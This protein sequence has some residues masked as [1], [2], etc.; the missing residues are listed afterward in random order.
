MPIGNKNYNMIEIMS[1]LMTQ[2]EDKIPVE[3]KQIVRPFFAHVSEMLANDKA[4]PKLSLKAHEL[5]VFLALW[6]E[7][8]PSS[9]VTVHERGATL[10]RLFQATTDWQKLIN[11]NQHWHFIQEPL[12]TQ[13]INGDVSTNTSRAVHAFLQMVNEAP[14][15]H[16]NH[17]IVTP[18]FANHE[19]PSIADYKKLTCTITKGE[20]I[21]LSNLVEKLSMA[22][23]RRHRQ[24]LESGSFLVKGDHITV[25]H[26]STPT[27]YQ[28]SFF[29]STIERIIEAQDRRS[30]DMSSVFLPPVRFPITTQTWSSLPSTFSEITANTSTPTTGRKTIIFNSLQPTIVFPFKEI[31]D[32][33]TTTSAS[34]IIVFYDNLDRVKATVAKSP[35]KNITYYSH[36]LAHHPFALIAEDT[37]FISEASLTPA[38]K[39]SSSPIS[40]ERAL[41]LIGGLSIGKP[42]VHADHGIGIYEGMQT[43]TIENI[44]KEYLVL[45][46]AQGDALS[47][48]VEFAHKITP[49]IGEGS[50]IVHRLGGTLW[51]K[52][53]KRAKQDAIAFAKELLT[54]A[55]ARADKKRTPYYFDGELEQKLTTSFPFT[56][57]LDQEQ[58]WHEVQ[59]DMGKDQPMDRLIVGDVGFGKTEIAMRAA[60]HAVAMGKQVA[61][62]A[63]TTLLVQ[64]HLDTFQNRL[65]HLKQNIAA[66]SRFSSPTATRLAR[67]G[68]EQDTISIAIGTHALLAKKTI[69]KNLGLVVID[70]EQRFGVGQKE[71]LKKIRASVDV[72][73]LSATPIPRTLSMAL[74]GLRQLSIIATP[75]AG[76]QDIIQQ[77]APQNDSLIIQA[78]TRE[79][80]RGGQVY[81]VAPKVRQLGMIKEHIQA[82]VPHARIAIAHGQMDDTALSKVIHDFDTHGIDI[83]VASS[84]VENGLDLPTANTMLIF[85]APHFGL[86]DLYQLRGRIGRRSAQGYA[87][88]FYTQSELTDVQRARL[89]AL[90]EAS[91]L[92]S[93]WLIAQRDLEI[94]GAGNLLGAD[95]SGTA[96]AIGVQLYM[97]M[98][99]DTLENEEPTAV[100]D[101]SLP[102][103]ALL[104]THY[105]ADMKE[106]TRW[107]LRLTRAK[108]SANLDQH[109]TELT[110]QYGLLPAETKNLLLLISLQ[111]LAV[112]RGISKITC[113]KISPTDDDP[114]VRLEITARNLPA[115][116]AKLNALGNWTVR[117][118]TAFWPTN[119]I[120]AET[121]QRLVDVL[122]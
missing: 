114:F 16:S 92:G 17:F 44:Q 111:H 102:I 105:I 116:L 96:N 95:Q 29:G 74:S 86:A 110:R 25:K 76:R 26:P 9:L 58:T 106:R 81:A 15:T 42:A 78:I 63:P 97:D 90:T 22:G 7:F 67:Q 117:N 3:L 13:E 94:R 56:L 33:L 52:T 57:T 72:L 101:I 38:Q 35:Q 59:T 93:G 70:E 64:Q 36:E 118:E 8:I 107:Y 60:A 18:D 87:Y 98:I 66:L 11:V 83:L 30:H 61:I 103:P 120:T 48:P 10:Q 62:L 1:N 5:P 39:T 45:R 68:I 88:F 100:V 84:I 4:T 41:E 85:N 40:Y 28:I 12:T 89:T 71:H 91:R 21:T 53:K 37:L 119:E 20:T 108:T 46:Y 99:H 49:Y 77:V 73:S 65:P 24:S 115:L 55:R 34:N 14:N 32:P 47:V 121:V 50:P 109:V 23:Y 2:N 51:A 104:P 19:I 54:I 113:T 6:S 43:R 82:L 75:P 80:K 69:W 122:Q 79:L 27:T 112:K 31:T